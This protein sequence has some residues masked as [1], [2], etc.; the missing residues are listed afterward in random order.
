MKNLQ[1]KVLHHYIHAFFA[2]FMNEIAI[3]LFTN[4]FVVILK[5]ENRTSAA[6]A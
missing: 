6:K 5:K 3:I 1:T 2:I 4:A